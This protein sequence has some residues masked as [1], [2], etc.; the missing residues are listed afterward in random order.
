MISRNILSKKVKNILATTTTNLTYNNKFIFPSTSGAIPKKNFS[1]ISSP[2]NISNKTLGQNLNISLSTKTGVNRLVFFDFQ[3]TT[4]V[5]PRVLDAM[6]PYLTVRY[7][8]PHSNSHEYGW[9]AEKA[10]E[11][12]REV[13]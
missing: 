13:S 3:S 5:D 6:L 9:E 1:E 10:V 7:G 4:P 8:N 11:K 12:A 2:S